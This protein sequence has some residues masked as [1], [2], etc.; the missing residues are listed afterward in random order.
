[1]KEFKPLTPFNFWC[2]KVLPIVY[3]ESLSYYEVLCK[4][5][6]LLN[7][8]IKQTNI[9]TCEVKNL[10]DFVNTQLEKYTVEQLTEWLNDGTLQTMV[11]NIIKH[12]DMK[13]D[14]ESIIS[15]N[16][17][18]YDYTTMMNE[19]DIFKCKYKDMLT[20][21][22]LGKSFLGRSIPL[23]ILGSTNATNKCLI[24]GQQHARE[25]HTSQL[26]LKQ[27]EFYCEN[28]NNKYNDEIVS[29]IFND[30]AIYF[31][32][33]TN[34]DGNMLVVH[35]LSSIPENT[36]NYNDLINNIKSALEEKIRTDIQKNSDVSPSWDLY[37]NIEWITETKGHIPNYGFREQDLFMWKANLQ[38]IDLHYNCWENG[39]NF[40][41]YSRGLASGTYTQGKF[42]LQNEIGLTGWGAQENIGL[43]ELISRENL[44]QYTLSY[45]GRSPLIQWN[46]DL[47]DAI[48]RRVH[49]CAKDFAQTAQVRYSD[50]YYSRVGFCGFFV[51]WAYTNSSQSTIDKTI[52]MILETGWMR[53]PPININNG[54]YLPTAPI[55]PCPLPNEQEPFIWNSWKFISLL[56]MQKYVRYRDMT[57]KYDEMLIYNMKP[58]NL[59]PVI[60]ALDSEGNID[61]TK[62]GGKYGMRYLT[63]QQINNRIFLNGYI[64]LQNMGTLD[65]VEI[66]EPLIVRASGIIK[67]INEGVNVWQGTLN[68]ISGY[69]CPLADKSALIITPEFIKNGQYVRFYVFNPITGNGVYV[70]PKDITVPFVINF[71]INYIGV[72][73]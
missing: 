13:E 58:Q 46:Y 18:S 15:N 19:I 55:T 62:Y 40:E 41:A 8:T 31:V 1:M 64:Q 32:P 12:M 16:I 44:Y 25:I 65:D 69:T 56:Y 33:M 35:G 57:N 63:Q 52:T 34:P 53:F 27:I 70:R 11:D 61:D 14:Y 59:T 60:G 29:D 71:S 3:D 42:A 22:E 66:S 24:V 2:Q 39:I 72:N 54:D 37:P 9:L 50:V 26:L 43:R 10:Y 30:N 68:R 17:R 6:D 36:P 20:V 28:W 67:S 5:R 49:G 73:Q 48:L 7:E 21:I 51:S 23:I 38:G 45:H 47:H 4:L